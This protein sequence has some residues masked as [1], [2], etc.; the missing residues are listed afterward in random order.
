MSSNE[1]V[2]L[3]LEATNAAYDN[4]PVARMNDHVVRISVMTEPYFWHLHPDSDETF[5]VLEG[6]LEIEYRDR[7]VRLDVAQLTTVLKGVEHRTRPIGDRSVNLTF[8][9]A[10]ASTVRVGP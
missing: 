8:E 7:I 1:V 9:H 3:R 4:H 10:A 2:D 6:A 5:L